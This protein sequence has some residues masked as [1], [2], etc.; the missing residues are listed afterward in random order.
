[1]TLE[2]GRQIRAA[3]VTFKPRRPRRVVIVGDTSDPSGL[4][5]IARHPRPDLVI[6]EA[7]ASNELR[8][9]AMRTGHSTPAM[10]G[11]FAKSLGARSL[12]LTHLS[13]RFFQ[14]TPNNRRTR[15]DDDGNFTST[16]VLVD[17]AREAFG[18]DSVLAAHD[19]MTLALP[20]GGLVEAGEDDDYVYVPPEISG[21]GM[22]PPGEPVVAG[23]QRRPRQTRG[24]H[25]DPPALDIL[26]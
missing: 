26:K 13:P 5:P 6:H 4:I 22:P 12:V 16:D 3:D 14:A 21:R 9:F 19:F 20:A 11:R 24:P 15:P 25:V 2:D 18:S 10:A 1:V 23:S 7:T 17:Q 8:D